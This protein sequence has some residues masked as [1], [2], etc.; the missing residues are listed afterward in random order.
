MSSLVIPLAGN[1]S[2]L[3]S[4]GEDNS[5]FANFVLETVQME[6]SIKKTW[7]ERLKR[8]L[9]LREIFKCYYV[10]YVEKA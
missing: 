8:T 9:L 3:H 4:G 2:G 6:T 1:N 10:C 7:T 5:E